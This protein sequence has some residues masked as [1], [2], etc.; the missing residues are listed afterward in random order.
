[1]DQQIRISK[2][3]DFSHLQSLELS[4]FENIATTAEYAVLYYKSKLRVG[5]YEKRMEQT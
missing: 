3:V 2:D 5:S 4:G 1:M